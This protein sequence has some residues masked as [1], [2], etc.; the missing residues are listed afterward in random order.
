MVHG[1]QYR[2]VYYLQ[3]ALP[4]T[5]TSAETFVEKGTEYIVYVVGIEIFSHQ[6][7]KRFYIPA[8]YSIKT[9]LYARYLGDES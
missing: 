8:S 9:L 5:L 3:L 1:K 2:L 6:H 4:R 7:Q